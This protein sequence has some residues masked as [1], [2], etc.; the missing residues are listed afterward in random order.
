M[1]LSTYPTVASR[2][3]LVNL[4]DLIL[5]L[6]HEI[7]VDRYH[8]CVRSRLCVSSVSPRWQ[9]EKAS[10]IQLW[11]NT[12]RTEKWHEQYAFPF[13]LILVALNF[14]QISSVIPTLVFNVIIFREVDG[15]WEEEEK[16]E[17]HSDWVRDVAWA[18][19]VG[20]PISTIATCS[21]VQY[22]QVIGCYV[23]CAFN[24]RHKI[25]C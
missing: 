7:E 25:M 22:V 11:I 3:R 24:R 21:Q 1:L 16:L 5:K 10:M 20:L 19:N 2:L 15:Q 17:A 13:A 23:V 8:I 18:P 4:Q 9:T 6:W 14:Q 12:C